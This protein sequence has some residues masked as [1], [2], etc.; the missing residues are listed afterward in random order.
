MSPDSHNPKSEDKNEL[1]T[2]IEELER[3]LTHLDQTTPAFTPNLAWFEQQVAEEK[4]KL[5]TRLFRDLAL[6]WLIALLAL[7]ISYTLLT[8]QP[9]AFLTLQAVI[10]IVP[11]V[12]IILKK[13][14]TSHEE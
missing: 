1:S 8:Q 6:F 3:G 4:R 14:V 9:T 7:T 12:W 11:M 13:Q 5:R 2:V 10:V